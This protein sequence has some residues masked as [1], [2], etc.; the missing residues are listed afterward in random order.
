MQQIKNLV[1]NSIN[2]LERQAK[3]QH[4]LGVI[5]LVKKAVCPLCSESLIHKDVGGTHIYTCEAC[6][7]VGLEYYSNIDAIQL[8]GYLIN[9]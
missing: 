9:K 8:K 3:Q 4:N 5:D 6:P 7:F 2:E 1:E